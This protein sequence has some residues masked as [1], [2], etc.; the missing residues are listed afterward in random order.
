MTY[1]DEAYGQ[2]PQRIDVFV[3][4]SWL[5]KGK[6]NTVE[7]GGWGAVVMESYNDHVQAWSPSG[8]T[9]EQVSNS[10]GAEIQSAISGLKAVQ[11]REDYRYGEGRLPRI[12]LHTDQVDWLPYFAALR[13]NPDMPAKSN[14]TGPLLLELGKMVIDMGVTV[15]YTSHNKASGSRGKA[16]D[17]AMMAVPHDL[18]S[19]EAWKTRLL[20]QGRLHFGP[21]S[22]A[23]REGEDVDSFISRLFPAG[24]APSARER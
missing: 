14:K 4:G 15:E 8:P 12:V 18:A 6:S 13:K 23:P 5:S 17:D 1:L 9:P 21:D 19:Q 11:T 22:L 7:A 16:T 3:D 24:L 10:A 20:K 2:R